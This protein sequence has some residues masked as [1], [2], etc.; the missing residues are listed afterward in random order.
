MKETKPNTPAE[1]SVQSQAINDEEL[2]AVA[3]GVF[4]ESMAGVN[5]ANVNVAN[6]NVASVA[7]E[8][9]IPGP[10]AYF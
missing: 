5:V 9:K 6:V 1:F 2:D 8:A 4:P 7:I 10:V 3:G